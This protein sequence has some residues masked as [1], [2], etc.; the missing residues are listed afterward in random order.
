[1]Y[2]D[3]EPLAFRRPRKHK[4]RPMFPRYA[5]TCEIK[6][7]LCAGE[8]FFVASADQHSKNRAVFQALARSGNAATLLT[9]YIQSRHAAPAPPHSLAAPAKHSRNAARAQE[10]VFSDAWR[11]GSLGA[12]KL[13]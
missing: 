1:M 7:D 8:I 12:V 11:C 6:Q 9:L 5:R 13:C 4:F 10:N 3:L 2:H